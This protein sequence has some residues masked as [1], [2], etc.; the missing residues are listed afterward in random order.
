MSLSAPKVVTFAVSVLLAFLGFLGFLV[1]IPLISG[2]AFW[3]L[4]IG[5]VLLA[6]GNLLKG[7]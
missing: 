1:E 3:L 7:L 4:F 2:I 6:L 5:F